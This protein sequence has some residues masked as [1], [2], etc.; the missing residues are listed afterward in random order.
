[1]NLY[2]CGM[3]LISNYSSLSFIDEAPPLLK[4]LALHKNSLDTEAPS[5]TAWVQGWVSPVG[6]LHRPH[7]ALADM[8]KMSQAQEGISC[9]DPFP[10]SFLSQ[11][12]SKYE[13]ISRLA[14]PNTLPLC[15]WN[16]SFSLNNILYEPCEGVHLHFISFIFLSFPAY[17]V[18]FCTTTERLNHSH[19][20]YL[21]FRSP[22]S[23]Q[24]H[25][26]HCSFKLDSQAGMTPDPFLL[27]HPSRGEEIWTSV[28]WGQQPLLN[29]FK[30]VLWSSARL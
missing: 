8:G 7:T 1:M 2:I 22:V 6:T 16:S 24:Y 19:G 13:E 9:F 27:K 15:I 10:H 30:K 11:Y 20:S 14:S 5:S 17:V 3:L 21:L 26:C 4:I 12:E 25:Q 18:F 29:H 23:A 28:K